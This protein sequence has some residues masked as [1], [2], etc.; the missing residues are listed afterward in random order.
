MSSHPLRRKEPARP[1]HN[2]YNPNGKDKNNNEYESLSNSDE[3]HNCS[4]SDS[5]D[6]YE[7]EDSNDDDS[8]NEYDELNSEADEYYHSG[9]SELV[10]TVR[11]DGYGGG[12]HRNKRRGVFG[13]ANRTSG[14]NSAD[15]PRGGYVTSLQSH[16]YE[17]D[18]SEVWRAFVAQQ[19]LSNRGQWWTTGKLRALRR[20]GL[21]FLVGLLQ[22]VIAATCNMASR[23]LSSIKFEHVYALLEYNS[24]TKSGVYGASGAS[25]E[26]G[27]IG[28]T[29][30]YAGN[31]AYYTTASPTRSKIPHKLL[32]H[33]T[34]I[35][36]T[37]A[38]R[39]FWHFC[40][41]KRSS[42]WRPPFLFTSNQ[43]PED[44]EFPKSNAS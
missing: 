21:T 43:S 33:W 38:I 32:R 34:N 20:W 1:T 7:N 9:A 8:D 41:T 35:G 42:L 5:H 29:D 37:L 6:D 13:S 36:S 17:P 44:P 15:P 28:G 19:H 11:G 2:R 12:G 3:D 14:E 30:D 25:D 24:M 22:A 23:R 16:N 4:T 27:G 31:G 40:S 18:E 10:T 26:I 39:P